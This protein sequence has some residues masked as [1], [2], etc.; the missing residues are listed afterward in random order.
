M[1]EATP[2]SREPKMYL[3][4]R[5]LISDFYHS[6]WGTDPSRRMKS[7][8]RC[9]LPRQK[10]GCSLNRTSSSCFCSNPVP[11]IK[12]YSHL[13][14]LQELK[15]FPLC[16]NFA[17]VARCEKALARPSQPQLPLRPVFSSQL[18]LTVRNS[19]ERFRH[20]GERTVPRRKFGYAFPIRTTN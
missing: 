18:A 8:A 11:S 7:A 17:R 2:S 15:I 10:P 5:I 16:L 14:S 12:H 9:T 20:L 4:F 19:P 1:T 13:T 6:N 3:G